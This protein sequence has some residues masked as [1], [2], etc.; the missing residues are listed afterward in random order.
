MS[1]T[2]SQLSP[3]SAELILHT[4][5]EGVLGLDDEHRITRVNRAAECMLGWPVDEL[6]GRNLHELLQ[7]RRSDGTYGRPLSRSRSRCCT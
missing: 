7:P 4:M 1:G 6:L 2:E 5:S 3:A